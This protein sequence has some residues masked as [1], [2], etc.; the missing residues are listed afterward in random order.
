M[1]EGRP[2]ARHIQP[3]MR[4]ELEFIACSNYVREKLEEAGLQVIDVIHH[5]LVREQVE[6]ARRLVPT[7]RENLRRLHGDKVIFG[8]VAFWH[9][10]KGL[11]LLA[12][13]CE[14][15]SSKRDDFVVHLVTNVTAKRKLPPVKG[16]YVDTVFGTRSREEILAF[17][18]AIDFLIVPSLAEG[19]CLP[20]VEANAMGTPAIHALYPPLTEV[21]T[22]EANITFQYELVAFESLGEGIDYELHIYSPAALAQAMEEAIEMILNDKEEYE[23]RCREARKALDRFDAEK[24]Y[25]RLLKYIGG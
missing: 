2:T 1:I 8:A 20:L 25:P 6:V 4:R 7:A 19:F 17:L 24:L 18:G 16:L 5:G 3:W 22:P 9:R 10:R 11:E 21:T 12:K 23:R 15:L 13:A 14:M